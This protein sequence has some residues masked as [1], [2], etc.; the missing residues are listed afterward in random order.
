MVYPVMD[1]ARGLCRPGPEGAICPFPYN[2]ISTWYQ[3]KSVTD[4]FLLQDPAA[5]SFVTAPPPAS[6]GPAREVYHVDRFTI[7][8]YAHD[9]AGALG[10]QTH[11]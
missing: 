5:I 8:V 4:T 11:A 3:P 6:L 2:A 10:A 9:I 1:N 7:Y